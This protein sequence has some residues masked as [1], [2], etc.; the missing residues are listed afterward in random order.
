MRCGQFPSRVKGIVE[1]ADDRLL[2]FCAAETIAAHSQRFQAEL[3]GV[4]AALGQMYGEDFFALLF[5]R[6]IDEEKF[7]QPPFAQQFRREL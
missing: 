1:S 7:V 2:D 4:P 5:R 6:Q 3:P